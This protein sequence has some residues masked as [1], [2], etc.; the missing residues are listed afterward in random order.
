LPQSNPGHLR[1][2]QSG[3]RLASRPA[4]P[5]GRMATSAGRPGPDRRRKP[6]RKPHPSRQP[7]DSLKISLDRQFLPHGC[8]TLP[9][10]AIFDKSH[11]RQ[12]S[13]ARRLVIEATFAP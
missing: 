8:D 10:R 3:P 13:S 1:R 5:L 4:E 2:R 9:K 7:L 12:A 6:P 11:N